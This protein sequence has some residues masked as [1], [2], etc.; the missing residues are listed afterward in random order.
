VIKFSALFSILLLPLASSASAQGGPL[1]PD[2]FA[3]IEGSLRSGSARKAAA[4]PGSEEIVDAPLPS[5]LSLADD[6]ARFGRFA[7]GGSD[8]NW[9]IGFNNA[10]IVRLPPRPAGKFVKAFIGAKIGRAKTKPKKK[11]PW[12]HTVISGKVYMAI[13]PRPAFSS[14]NSFFL[15]ETADIPLEVHES[16]Y[17]PGTGRSQWFWAEVPL[18]LV[19][20]TENNY[21]IVW[22]P[23]REFRDSKRAPILAAAPAS[24]GASGSAWNNH[25]ILG[26]P[27]RSEATAL[28][29]PIGLQPALAIKLVPENE[30]TVTVTAFE[31]V[32]LEKELL[33]RFSVVGRDVEIAWIEMSSDELEWSRVSTFSRH[34]PF[35]LSVARS[36]IP[37]RGAYLR[38]VA[39]DA[40]GNEGQSA[41]IFVLGDEN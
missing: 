10:W 20:S 40:Y 21:L 33:S 29:T 13:A 5:Y 26:V 14:E 19:S 6:P 4:S 28:E 39:R 34:S 23:T 25:S 7:D 36:I 1:V 35:A 16:I 15:A 11:R 12:E 3:Q 30:E 31:T 22:S 37:P 8:S 24:S 38:A 2:P 9:Y 18:G 41:T 32:S 27:P 17:R